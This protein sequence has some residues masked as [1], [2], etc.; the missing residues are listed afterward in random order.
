MTHVYAV[1]KRDPNF[2]FTVIHKI[3][4]FLS[5]STQITSIYQLEN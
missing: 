2:P 1:H 3:E 5:E 4:E